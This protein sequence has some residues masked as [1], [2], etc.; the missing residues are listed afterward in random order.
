MVNNNNNDV[1]SS[2]SSSRSSC[3]V[4]LYPMS[5]RCV[6]TALDVDGAG[7]VVPP[8]RVLHH[9]RV[10]PRILQPCSFDLDSGEFPVGENTR[11]AESGERRQ[12]G[13]GMETQHVET[14]AAIG[15]VATAA[16]PLSPGC[17][18]SGLMWG[19]G[20][21]QPLGNVLPPLMATFTISA[22]IALSWSQFSLI[23]RLR[24]GEAPTGKKNL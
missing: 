11:A 18:R 1:D 7:G 15:G 21:T 23:I 9:T 17:A 6:L 16:L 20:F 19:P 2:S 14:R 12:G 3:A 24:D 4:C 13:S 22:Y 8:Q 10:I 5:G